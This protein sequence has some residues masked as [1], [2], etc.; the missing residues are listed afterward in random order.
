M[1]ISSLASALKFK[2]E[3]VLSKHSHECS[4]WHVRG[5]PWL[6]ATGSGKSNIIA[7]NEIH[8][9]C[10]LYILCR[11]TQWGERKST[12][13]M[14]SSAAY[15][16]P[17][18]L[19]T[20]T[21]D[22]LMIGPSFPQSCLLASGCTRTHMPQRCTRSLP[23]MYIMNFY[24]GKDIWF[25]GYQPQLYPHML[26]H[27]CT[28]PTGCVFPPASSRRLFLWDKHVMHECS[29]WWCVSG[30]EDGNISTG[31]ISKKICLY[32]G[33]PEV[34]KQKHKTHNY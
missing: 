13:I 11:I 30:A 16:F 10:S 1:Q 21:N 27:R 17:V 4:K 33:P 32:A 7:G 31:E 5:W 18:K 26:L 29:K 25:N 23:H 34:N 8:K 2:S 6:W 22:F 24:P 19:L 20:S 15:T 28:V 3:L 14:Q 12:S 9:F